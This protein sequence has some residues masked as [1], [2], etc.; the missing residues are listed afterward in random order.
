MKS[1]E[2]YVIKRGGASRIISQ[3]LSLSFRYC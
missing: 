1:A 3:Y 2:K